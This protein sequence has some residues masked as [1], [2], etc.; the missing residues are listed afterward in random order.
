MYNTNVSTNKE[1]RFII[2]LAII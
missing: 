1:N 2:A